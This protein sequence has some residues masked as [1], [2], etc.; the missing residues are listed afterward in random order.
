MTPQVAR[1]VA[2][3]ERD[4]AGPSARALLEKIDAM[5]AVSEQAK[6][7]I[8]TLPARKASATQTRKELQRIEAALSKSRI[9]DILRTVSVEIENTI[10]KDPKHPVAL[11]RGLAAEAQPLM[12]AQLTA[13]EAPSDDVKSLLVLA[14]TE[15]RTLA[16]RAQAVAV[17]ARAL[18]SIEQMERALPKLRAAAQRKAAPPRRAH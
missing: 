18:F 11:A 15:Q 17:A 10:K 2:G 1:W 14:Q 13:G 16:I 12:K 3:Q 4:T 7:V 6:R 5:R 8:A 9:K